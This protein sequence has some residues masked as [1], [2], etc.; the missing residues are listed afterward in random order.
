MKIELLTS[1]YRITLELVTEW[2][3]D[4]DNSRK[5]ICLNLIFFPHRHVY[6][7]CPRNL[8]FSEVPKVDLSGFGNE[9][10]NY[11]YEEKKNRLW[12][13]TR[14]WATDGIFQ[15]VFQLIEHGCPMQKMYS[16]KLICII[17]SCSGVLMYIG[18]SLDKTK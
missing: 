14:W 16:V 6:K 8:F 15:K 13:T 18:H 4:P 2:N 10:F 3:L 11:L 7:F 5:Y 17:F 12:C 9:L 1:L